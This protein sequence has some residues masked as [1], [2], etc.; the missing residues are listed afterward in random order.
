MR[1]E[2]RVTRSLRYGRA[3]TLE[4]EVAPQTLLADALPAPGVLAD[5]MAATI[6]ALSN[7]RQYPPLSQSV[8]PGDR[9]VIAAQADI[10]CLPAIVAGVTSVLDQAG[11]EQENRRVVLADTSSTAGEGRSV[12]GDTLAGLAWEWHDPSDKSAL[13]YLAAEESG[14]PIYL[15]R[16]LCDADVIIPIGLLRPRGALGYLG[17]HS[18]LFPAFSDV[19]TRQRFS[20]WTAQAVLAARKKLRREAIEVDWL[21]GLQLAMQIV[22]GPGDTVRHVLAGLLSEL[23]EE[24][25]ALAE[26]AWACACPQRADFVV[27]AIGG[28]PS[29]QTWTNFARALHAALQVSMPGGTIVLCTEIRCR[30]GA[31]LQR[32]SGSD[33]DERLWRRLHSDHTDDAAAAALLLEHRQSQHIYLLSELDAAVVEAWGIGSVQD[34]REISRL[35]E[36]AASCLL[37]DDAHRTVVRLA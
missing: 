10:P 34:P 7:P 23:R 28:G 22:A 35:S 18:G 8:V 19:A 21:L 11:L 20:G 27:A 26:A 13:C 12:D 6:A 33:D 30:P 3:S 14:A 17:L 36:H 9:V 16:H 37:L 15:N 1:S 2:V 4:L 24:G 5:P 25:R 29:E 32:L 31:S